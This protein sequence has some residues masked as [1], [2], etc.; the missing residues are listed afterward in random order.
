MNHVQ[1]N[2]ILEYVKYT[3]LE[4]GT[5]AHLRVSGVHSDIQW[6]PVMAVLWWCTSGLT[7]H[8]HC[9]SWSFTSQSSLDILVFIPRVLWDER[10]ECCFFTRTSSI[11]H[12]LFPSWS[13][14]SSIHFLYWF[15]MCF[16]F[17]LYYSICIFY[18]AIK[19]VM[20]H[21]FLYSEK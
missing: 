1:L 15:Q 7:Y 4:R 10:S 6:L 9:G 3:F 8:C 14:I 19:L 13:F 11:L 18:S 12:N 17:L 5:A 20:S 2:G 16:I 21:I